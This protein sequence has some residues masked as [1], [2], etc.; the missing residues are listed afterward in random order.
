MKYKGWALKYGGDDNSYYV[1]HFESEN[2][3]S[4]YRVKAHADLICKFANECRYRPSTPRELYST[5]LRLIT[6]IIEIRMQRG[7][8]V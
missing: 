3:D 4:L 6:E 7:L 5:K 8:I 1:G 2:P